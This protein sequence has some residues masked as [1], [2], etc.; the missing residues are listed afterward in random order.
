MAKERRKWQAFV[1]MVMELKQPHSLRPVCLIQQQE[2]QTN[3]KDN[4]PPVEEATERKPYGLRI[5]R[6]LSNT[7]Q[8]FNNK[9]FYCCLRCHI[10]TCI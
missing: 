4:I 8:R 1:N 6:I 7:S 3:T 10:L 9:N 5:F 2:D